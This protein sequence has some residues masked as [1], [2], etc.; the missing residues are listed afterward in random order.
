VLEHTE[1]GE[2]HKCIFE[3]GKLGEKVARYYFHQLISALEHINEKGFAHQDI[4]LDNVMLDSM[5]NLKLA[6]FG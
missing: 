1:N 3:H 4:K 5:F 6:D 2:M